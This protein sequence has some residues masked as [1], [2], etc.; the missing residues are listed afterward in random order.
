MTV[1]PVIG[2]R[3]GGV[4][5]KLARGA[6]TATSLVERSCGKTVGVCGGLASV[7]RNAIDTLLAASLRGEPASDLGR[8]DA[9]AMLERI[10]YHGI[11]GLLRDAPGAM[12]GWPQEISQRVSKEAVGQAMWELRHRHLLNDL[13]A[14]LASA[15]VVTLL[16]KGTALAYDL[17]P[18]PATR[19]RG[20]S[21]L[22]IDP[23]ALATARRVFEQLGFERVGVDGEHA[24][25]F[26]LQ[27]VWSQTCDGAMGHHIDLHWQTLK[28]PAL[29]DIL[30]VGEC[31]A[32]RIALPR[33]GPDAMGLDRVRTLIH[34]CIHRM[35]NFTSP[36]FVG[37]QTYYG[38]DR[39][40][41]L[42]DIDLLARALSDA[43]WRSFVRLAIGAGVA[44]ACLDGLLT[45]QRHLA[46]P[47]PACVGEALGAASTR[48]RAAVYLRA[49]Q[50]G[51]AWQDLRAIRGVG[52]KYEYRLARALPSAAFVRDKFPLHAGLPLPLLYARRVF[53]LF[54]AR[55]AQSAER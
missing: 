28:C 43:E 29:S 40:I 24:D 13:L 10:T 1:S 15:K 17:Y 4:Q 44:A 21:D 22:L 14:G 38:G 35:L 33:L 31:I 51:R 11:A 9:D 27:E 16:L 55:P 45:T 6:A 18:S 3:N 52:R 42:N 8:A 46:T 19:A 30:P 41:W 36:Y 25:R 34:T 5:R 32:H 26:A 23:S 54:R 49:R 2:G 12:A 50:F 20:D 39:L 7:D 47:V 37:E 48:S 53:D